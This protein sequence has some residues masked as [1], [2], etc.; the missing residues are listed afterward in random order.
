MPYLVGILTMDIYFLVCLLCVHVCAHMYGQVCACLLVR[1]AEINVRR[2]PHEQSPLCFG[3]GSRAGTRGLLIQ[4]DWL[5]GKLQG[6]TFLPCSGI[7]STCHGF[8]FLHRCWG[9]NS[10]PPAHVT[11]TRPTEPSSEPKGFWDSNRSL[12]WKTC[13]SFLDAHLPSTWLTLG[14]LGN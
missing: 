13:V 9:R 14:P 6:L 8:G 4:S 2:C 3:T 10:E 1:G 12:D 7:T 5:A 11:S